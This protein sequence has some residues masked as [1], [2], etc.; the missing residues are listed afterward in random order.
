M[1]QSTAR[2][3]TFKQPENQI[4]FMLFYLHYI[5]FLK[6]FDRILRQRLAQC[7][8]GSESEA[9]KEGRLHA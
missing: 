2:E 3:T 7:Y 5:F 9:L 1:S 6:Y 4:A 8:C